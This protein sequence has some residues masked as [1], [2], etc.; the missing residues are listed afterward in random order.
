MSE[1]YPAPPPAAARTPEIPDHSERHFSLYWWALVPLLLVI[2]LSVAGNLVGAVRGGLEDT[3]MAKLAG[4]LVCVMVM[5]VLPSWIAFRLGRGSKLAG[6]IVCVVMSGLVLASA[7][8]S[9]VTIANRANQRQTT[10]QTMT[11]WEKDTASAMEKAIAERKAA[12]VGESGNEALVGHLD[13]FATQTEEV[14]ATLGDTPEGKGMRAS[15]AVL[16]KSQ[17]A[18]ATYTHQVSEAGEL[19]L[20][21]PAAMSSREAIAAEIEK[22]DRLA[23]ANGEFLAFFESYETTLRG[24]FLK[25]GV[26]PDIAATLAK[27]QQALPAMQ[28]AMHIRQLEKEMWSAAHR[29]A[30]HLDQTWGTWHAS[31]DGLFLFDREEDRQAFDELVDRFFDLAEEQNRLIANPPAADAAT[32]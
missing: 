26:P 1:Q 3:S 32:P 30:A 7:A 22:V 5:I 19:V 10:Q 23:A 18:M 17:Q 14:A 31:D 28:Q 12:A 24:E 25:Q 8:V 11:Q 20:L 16:R 27:Q 2:L 13:R 21:D 4:S 15:A 29:I 9:W 6:S